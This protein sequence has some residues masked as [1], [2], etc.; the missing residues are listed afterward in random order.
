[1]NY[2]ATFHNHIAISVLMCRFQFVQ[3]NSFRFA[4]KQKAITLINQIEKKIQVYM[5]KI[6]FNCHNYCTT[7]LYLLGTL[8]KR[9]RSI[10]IAGISPSEEKADKYTDQASESAVSCSNYS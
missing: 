2:E 10:I 6:N 5:N 4:L 3:R 8:M 7:Y 1:M 9:L